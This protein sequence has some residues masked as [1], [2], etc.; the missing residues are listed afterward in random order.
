RQLDRLYD[1][2]GNNEDIAAT[3]EVGLLFACQVDIHFNT[4]LFYGGNFNDGTH[5]KYSYKEKFKK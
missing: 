2:D 1:K 4:S 3:E 5:E